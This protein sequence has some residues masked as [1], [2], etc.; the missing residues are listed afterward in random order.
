MAAA[1]VGTKSDTPTTAKKEKKEK[2]EKKIRVP[3]ID[4]ELAMKNDDGRLTEVPGDFD[5]KEHKAPKKTDFSEEHIYMRFRA[6]ELDR[7][8]ELMAGRAEKLREQSDNL[9]KYG[10]PAQRAK[11]KRAQRLKSQLAELEEALKAEDIDIDD[12]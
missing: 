2:K 12:L 7:K 6:D 4:T 8:S 5:P 9:E 3:Y 1:K 11:V 10:D